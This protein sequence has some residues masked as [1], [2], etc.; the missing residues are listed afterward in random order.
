MISIITHIFGNSRKLVSKKKLYCPFSKP[1]F[2]FCQKKKEISEQKDNFCFTKSSYLNEQKNCEDESDKKPEVSMKIV[3]SEDHVSVKANEENSEVKYLSPSFRKDFME[4]TKFKLCILNT[5]VALS[6]YSYYSTSLH[7]LSDFIFFTSGTMCISMTSQVCNQIKEKFLDKKMRRTNN[8]PLPKQRMTDQ[9]AV[10]IGSS[11]WISSCFFYYLS[12][13]H[14]I[15]LSN[16][17]VLLYIKAYT[18][19][20]RNSNTSMHIGALV[21]ALPAILGSYAA[22]EH[23]FLESSLLLAGYIFAWQYPHFYGILYQNKEDYKNAGFNFISNHE[24]K[25]HIAYIQMLLA[26]CVMLYIVYRLHKSK[27]Q[28]INSTC[29]YAY[30]AFFIKNLIPV[31]KFY[32]N[33]SKYAKQIRKESYMPFLIVLFSFAFS[34]YRMRKQNLKEIKI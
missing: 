7:L 34:S 29:F 23:I 20:K 5:A 19:M 16:A 1:H 17:I 2:Y 22:T 18:P 6:T 8:R 27:D 33:P 3:V 11:L 26:M 15:L 24:N 14:A 9:T 21:G 30:L 10:L 25:T 4:I 28:V 31:L 12:C 32:S 13:P